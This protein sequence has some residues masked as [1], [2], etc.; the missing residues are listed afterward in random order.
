M[1]IAVKDMSEDYSLILMF[2]PYWKG[3]RLW[4]RNQSN[5][6]PSI[7]WCPHVNITND[8]CLDCSLVLDNE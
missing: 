6:Y 7:G 2:M 8:E 3:L 4:I 5:W 1:V